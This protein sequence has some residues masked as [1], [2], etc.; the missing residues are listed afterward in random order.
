MKGI[1]MILHKF[2]TDSVIITDKGN[3]KQ[4]LKI[5]ALAKNNIPALARML[6]EQ[7]ET[8][9]E[10]FKPHSFDECTLGKLA[11]DQSFLAYVVLTSDTHQCVGYFFQRSFFWGKSFRGY[12]TDYRWQ[13]QGINTMM[14]RCATE[15]SSLLGLRVF[16]TIAPSNIASMKS[17][18]TANKIQIIE[19]LKNGD[20]YVEYSPKE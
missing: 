2:S 10:Y 7:P 20:Y 13:R 12:I 8:A 5:A 16:G 3:G 18:Q 19:T 1:P 15:I 11:Q 9:F 6:A 4:C 14:N 17:A